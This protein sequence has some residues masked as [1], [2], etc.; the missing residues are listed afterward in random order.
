MALLHVFIV[1]VQHRLVIEK[2]DVLRA[3]FGIAEARKF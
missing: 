2:L 3:I 1:N